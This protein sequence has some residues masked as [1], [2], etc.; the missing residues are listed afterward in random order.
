MAV[1]AVEQTLTRGG[2][3]LTPN[4]AGFRKCLLDRFPM[5]I[6]LEAVAT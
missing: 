4:M 6:D 1:P 5:G 3:T 2:F